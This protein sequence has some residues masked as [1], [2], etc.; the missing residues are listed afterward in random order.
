MALKASLQHLEGLDWL[1]DKSTQGP[2]LHA[3]LY[4]AVICVAILQLARTHLG[5]V[6]CHHLNLDP[7]LTLV[8]TWR[9][10]PRQAC[11]PQSALPTA[12]CSLLCGWL[13]A[14][15][16][17][18]GYATISPGSLLYGV[19]YLLTPLLPACNMHTPPWAVLPVIS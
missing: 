15:A 10:G 19:Q 14:L 18:T 1:C 4:L 9:P 11:L 16:L 12:G 8:M 5:S 6:S 13:L 3:V 2:L 17:E 7:H